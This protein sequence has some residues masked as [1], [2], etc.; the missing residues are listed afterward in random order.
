MKHPSRYLQILPLLIFCQSLANSDGEHL[1]IESLGTYL[2]VD[3]ATLADMHKQIPATKKPKKPTSLQELRRPGK[4]M[5]HNVQRPFFKQFPALQKKIPLVELAD[6]PTPII[7]A[8]RLSARLHS[9]P[10]YIKQDDLSGKKLADGSRLFG[11]NKMRILEIE[12]GRALHADANTVMTLGCDGSNLVTAVAACADHLGLSMFGIIKPQPNA[13]VVQRNLLLMDH[14]GAQLVCS[15]SPQNRADNA[16]KTFK[17]IKKDTGKFPYFIPV[18]AS[19]PYSVI[20]FI[21]AA[22]EL[23]QQIQQG[24]MPEP[25]RIYIAAGQTVGTYVGLLIG[26]RLAGLRSKIYAVAVEPD[27][28][29]TLYAHEIKSLFT[30]AVQ[31]LHSLDP[32]FPLLAF[33]EHDVHVIHHCCGKKY[34]LFTKEAA[35]ALRLLQETEQIQLDGVYTAKAMAALLYDIQHAIKPN[36]TILFWNT[37]CGADVSPLIARHDYKKLPQPLHHYFETKV[38]EFDVPCS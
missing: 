31:L 29:G 2:K 14:Y 3:A 20:G 32:S 18:G 23:K 13:H 7:H 36:E 16:V 19:T 17:A 21:N 28:T 9:A 12:M 8:Q 22:F 15:T 24:I 35:H 1:C 30:Q 26:A 25:D 34:A 6:L 10:I 37:F 11:G 38:Q 5:V 4:K 27:A 33:N